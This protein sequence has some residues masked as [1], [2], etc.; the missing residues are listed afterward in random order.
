[1]GILCHDP[2]TVL[3]CI[4]GY[5]P[6]TSI[7]LQLPFDF[8][9]TNFELKVKVIGEVTEK[10]ILN[11]EIIIFQRVD[12]QKGIELLRF[13][14]LCGKCT[15]YETDDDW[16]TGPPKTH[17]AYKHY[18]DV[19]IR[20]NIERMIRNV[21]MVIVSTL[22]LKNTIQRYNRNTLIIPNCIDFRI[23]KG[24]KQKKNKEKVFIGYSGTNTHKSDFE[25]VVPAIQRI[26]KEYQG[27]V[28]FKFLG[29]IP[30]TL[31]GLKDIE[32]LDFNSDY[33]QYLINLYNSNIDIAIAPLEPSSFN[34]SKSSIKFLEYSACGFPGVY[35]DV[36]AYSET[37]NNGITGLLTSHT[38]EGW[39]RSIKRLIDDRKLRSN[40]SSAAHKFVKQNFSMEKAASLWQETLQKL[41]KGPKKKYIHSRNYPGRGRKINK[42]FYINAGGMWPH[43]YIDEMLIRAFMSIG[44]EVIIFDLKPEHFMASALVLNKYFVPGYLERLYQ[45]SRDSLHLLAEL[46]REKPDLIFCIQGYMIPKEVLAEIKKMD[47]AS[48]VWFLD[49]PYDLG[50]SI[51]FGK[52]FSYVFVQDRVSVDIHKKYGNPN[53]FFL[54]HGFDPLKTHSVNESLDEKYLSD[55]CVIGTAF[56]KRKRLVQALQPLGAKMRVIGPGWGSHIKTV[57]LEEAAKFY[58]GAKINL[59]IHREETDFCSHHLS[60]KALSPNASLFYIAGAGGFQIVDDSRKDIHKFFKEGKEVITFRNEEELVEKVEFF[61]KNDELRKKISMASRKKACA[62]HTYSHRLKEAINFIESTSPFRE[63]PS[64]YT[65]SVVMSEFKNTKNFKEVTE[66]NN[67]IEPISIEFSQTL[68]NEIAKGSHGFS[69]FI[70]SAIIHSFSRYIG[71]FLSGSLHSDILSK[72]FSYFENELD[73]GAITFFPINGIPGDLILSR[74]AVMN[75]GCFDNKLFTPTYSIKDYL[76]RLKISGYKVLESPLIETRPSNARVLGVKKMEEADRIYFLKK[77]KT[78]DLKSYFKVHCLCNAADLVREKG[79]LLAAQRLLR[80]AERIVPTARVY[81]SKGLVFFQKKEILQAERNLR[82]AFSNNPKDCKVALLYALSLYHIGKYEQSLSVLSS[83]L[84]DSILLSPK[85]RASAYAQMGRCKTK[86]GD[87]KGALSCFVKALE[88]DP[89]DHTTMKEFKYLNAKRK[90]ISLAHSKSQVTVVPLGKK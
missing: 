6:S 82:R 25:A 64:H 52:F 8:L 78:E 84:R 34:C 18:M 24:I 12:Q 80:E 23:F 9:K 45:N 46:K 16:I 55:I 85:M 26:L 44:F 5:V 86:I 56:P 65:L 1:M 57:S 31:W 33:V 72:C 70:N 36:P 54:P 21:D 48:A 61:L 29:F 71:I 7:R 60:V 11:A 67:L 88:L 15:I 2:R 4:Q 38:P 51:K 27:K 3:A 10:D 53:T 75:T 39:Y 76:L 69:Y 43:T 90:A 68:N 41:T 17:P 28:V 62:C 40:I 35:S 59:N 79:D 37:V 58:V 87:L 30:E 50:R 89:D 49:E 14:S 32:F 81:L 74:R 19:R 66:G 83:L 42:V 20:N 13:A 77:W 63:N 47:I 73:L 22:R